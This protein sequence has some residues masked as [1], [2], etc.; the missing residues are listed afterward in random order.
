MRSTMCPRLLSASLPDFTIHYGLHEPRQRATRAT[1]RR[2][3]KHVPSQSSPHHALR[4]LGQKALRRFQRR[5]SDGPSDKARCGAP[6]RTTLTP[7]TLEE[8]LMTANEYLA[9]V[10]EARMLREDGPYPLALHTEG[11]KFADALCDDFGSVPT[12]RYV[13]GTLIFRCFEVRKVPTHV[14]QS[15]ACPRAPY[16]RCPRTNSAGT[17]E[18]SP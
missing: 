3:S 8:R 13:K 6:R 15:T 11:K 17:G 18:E 14:R 12:I 2:T 4:V 7:S 16:S 10:L 5:C 9:R 1:P